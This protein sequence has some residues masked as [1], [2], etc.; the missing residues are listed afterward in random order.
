ME[1]DFK[2]RPEALWVMVINTIQKQSRTHKQFPNI[3]VFRDSWSG[4][5]NV[6]ANLSKENVDLSRLMKLKVGVG[7][8]A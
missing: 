6:G 3:L 8:L 5:D 7:V 1:V 4:I 2:T